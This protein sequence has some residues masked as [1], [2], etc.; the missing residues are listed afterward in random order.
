MEKSDMSER[1]GLLCASGIYAKL[2]IARIAA[3]IDWIV[4]DCDGMEHIE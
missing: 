1:I 3:N 2:E 4:V